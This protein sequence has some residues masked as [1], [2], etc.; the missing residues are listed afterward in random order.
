MQLDVLHGTPRLHVLQQ[1]LQ[2]QPLPLHGLMQRPLSLHGLMQRPR[3]LPR[4]LPQR[5]LLPKPGRSDFGECSWDPCGSFLRSVLLLGCLCMP[6]TACP[7]MK[8]FPRP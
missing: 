3:R 2:P 7:R 6:Y 4:R 5:L 1:P 8:G